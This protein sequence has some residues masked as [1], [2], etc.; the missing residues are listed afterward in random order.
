MTFS[1]NP[2]GPRREGDREQGREDQ[3]QGVN[4]KMGQEVNK[5]V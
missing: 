1:K 3:G 5:C 2:V 4:N